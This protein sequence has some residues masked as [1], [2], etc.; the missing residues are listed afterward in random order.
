MSK[1][2]IFTCTSLLLL[3]VA[4]GIEMMHALINGR[5]NFNLFALFIPVAIALFLSLPGA[6]LAANITFGLIYLLL[7]AMLVA[8]FFSTSA[9][10]LKAFGLET[11]FQPSFAIIFVFVAMVGS[12]LALLHW[13]LFSPPFEDHLGH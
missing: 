11:P 6:R 1:R 4:G 3:G 2:V 9:V 12:I 13:M 10:S 5:L 8:P 7:V